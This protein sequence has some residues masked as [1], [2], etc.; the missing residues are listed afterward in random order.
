MARFKVQEIG[1]VIPALI[2]PFDKDENFDEQRMRCLV[3]HL[4]KKGVEGL[5]L[6]GSTGEG[7]L[8][9]PEE[10]KKVVEVVVDQVQGRVPLI[11]HVGAIGTKISMDLAKQAVSAGVDAV[12]SV[13]PFYWKFTG[14]ELFKYYKDITEAAGI[15][16]IVYNIALAGLVGFDQV[17]KFASIDGVAGVKYTAASHFEIMRMKEELGRDFLVYSGCDEMALSGLSFGADGI[18]GSFYNLM[19]EIFITI[20]EAMKKKDLKTAGE[21]QRIANIIINYSTQKNY[22]GIMKRALGWMGLDAGYCRSPFH[23]FD[24]EEEARIKEDFKTLKE[25]HGITGIDF[26]DAI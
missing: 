21:K 15:P 20:N 25:T 3:D 6:T 26:L 12:S 11:A 4:L 1:G 2:T 19:P 23:N 17:K 24:R 16:M 5:Y 9:T 10:R 8:M 13:P 7:F 22:V 14:D 18:I